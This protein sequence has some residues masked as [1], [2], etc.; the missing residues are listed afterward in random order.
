MADEQSQ[1]D[2][3]SMFDEAPADDAPADIS[4]DNS[5]EASEEAQEILEKLKDK[6]LEEEA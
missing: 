6:K 4:E 1:D 3:D 2:V 5:E